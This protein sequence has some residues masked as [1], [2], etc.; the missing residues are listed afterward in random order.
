VGEVALARAAVAQRDSDWRA[1]EV[2]A[3][4]AASIFEDYR[5]PWRQVAALQAWGRVLDGAGRT[6]DAIARRG[7]ADAVLTKIG[8]PERWRTDDPTG[9]AKP[10]RTSTRPQRASTTLEP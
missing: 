6:D 1:A 2:A 4:Q 5:L 9:A 7:E 8:A 3:E 10:R